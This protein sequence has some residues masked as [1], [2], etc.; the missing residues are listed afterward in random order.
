MNFTTSMKESGKRFGS[1]GGVISWHAQ[2]SLLAHALETFYSNIFFGG[3]GEVGVW[4][5]PVVVSTSTVSCGLVN[6]CCCCVDT[7]LSNPSEM[8][9]IFYRRVIGLWGAWIISAS[10]CAGLKLEKRKTGPCPEPVVMQLYPTTIML[11][12]T[13]VLSLSQSCFPCMHGGCK[14]SQH[15]LWQGEE[16]HHVW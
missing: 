7:L 14:A 12:F 10:W 5:V 6:R 3:V 15:S 11:S 16:R 8:G 2:Y 1:P 4:G 13:L 9:F